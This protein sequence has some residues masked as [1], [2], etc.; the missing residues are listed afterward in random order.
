MPSIPLKLPSPVWGSDVHPGQNPLPDLL[1]TPSGLAILEIQGTINTPVP[2]NAVTGHAG[3]SSSPSTL[4]GRIVFPDFRPHDPTG[5]TAWMKRVHLYVGSH[6]RL[7]GG[8]TKLSS[9]LAV[10]RRKPESDAS[11]AGTEELEIA[12]IIYYKVLFS[13]RPEPVSE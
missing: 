4:V 11:V 7:T 5:S 2:D 6:Q 1:Q 3:D 8:V 13:S 10:I 9:P 12:E